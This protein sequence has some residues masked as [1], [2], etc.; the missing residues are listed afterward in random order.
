MKKD[1]ILACFLKHIADFQRVNRVLEECRG[2]FYDE[3]GNY[4][5]DGENLA[6]YLDKL[7]KKA[8]EIEAAPRDY[9]GLAAIK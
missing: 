2:C 8:L 1:K 6:D 9:S 7:E 5:P 3:S 4:L